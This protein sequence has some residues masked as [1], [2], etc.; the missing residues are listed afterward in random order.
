MSN[1]VSGPNSRSIG[2]NFKKKIISKYATTNRQAGTKY[3][4]QSQ[5]INSRNSAKQVNAYI[6]NKILASKF[7]DDKTHGSSLNQ[8]KDVKR[9]KATERIRPQIKNTCDS[10]RRSSKRSSKSRYYDKSTASKM[11]DGKKQSLKKKKKNFNNTTKLSTNFNDAPPD[12][13][14]ASIP[15]NS[16]YT[17]SINTN[18]HNNMSI[19]VSNNRSGAQ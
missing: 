10:V 17:M 13:Y 6:A 15:T 5:D 11:S 19:N 2:K 14:V 1:S 3:H 8:S 4:N 7:N 12:T 18:R 16:K 9:M